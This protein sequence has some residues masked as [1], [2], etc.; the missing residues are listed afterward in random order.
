MDYLW[1]FLVLLVVTIAS[2]IVW[3]EYYRGHSFGSAVRFSATSGC[4][5]QN[6][7]Q[8]LTP[9]GG[10]CDGATQGQQCTLSCAPGQHLDGAFEG[11]SRVVYT[12]LGQQWN[13]LSTQPNCTAETMCPPLVPTTFLNFRPGSVCVGAKEGDV[14]QLSC[15]PG[16]YPQG[17]SYA[18][19]RNGSWSNQLCCGCGTSTAQSACFGCPGCSSG[20]TGMFCYSE[21]GSYSQ[22][23]PSK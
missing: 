10:I 13:S 22:V 23:C 9:C 5:R 6:L 3:A 4:M 17:Q 11:Q 7:P 19:C 2:V 14:C 12:C 15:G 8:S 1:I 18:V 20:G 21:G 16:L